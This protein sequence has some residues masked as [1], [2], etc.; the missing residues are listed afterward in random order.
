MKNFKLSTRP[1]YDVLG[2]ST[3]IIKTGK[4]DNGYTGLTTT[5]TPND[6][7]FI[8]SEGV[9]QEN[10]INFIQPDIFDGGFNYGEGTIVE[11]LDSIQSSQ[12]VSR[13][14]ITKKY[15]GSTNTVTSDFIRSEGIIEMSDPKD[16]MN[17]ASIVTSYE[18][19]AGMFIEGTRAFSSDNNPWTDDDEG[20][21]DEPDSLETKAD[22]VSIGE[23]YFGDHTNGP[24]I[25]GVGFDGTHSTTE[26]TGVKAIS[27]GTI[28]PTDFTYKL[29]VRIEDVDGN[30]ETYSLLLS[31]NTD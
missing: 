12:G 31:R 25:R 4:S 22:L 26:T 1:S 29:P 18:S 5:I 11:K 13:F 17:D 6:F 19:G 23:L 20:T 15:K 21:N 8:R 16:K 27:A 9:K 30:V 24:V 2:I 10:L 3:V 28:T 14:L 7:R